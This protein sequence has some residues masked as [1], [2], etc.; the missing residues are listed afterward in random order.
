MGLIGKF[1]QSVAR[2]RAEEEERAQK[3]LARARTASEREKARAAI[4]QERMGTRAQIA[5]AKTALLKAEAEKKKAA[6]ALKEAG[7]GQDFFGGLRRMLVPTPAKK[8]R[9]ATRPK[10]TRK[11]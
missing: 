6:K 9:R 8:K 5:K 7:N 2:Y 4:Q 11:K 10:T 3:R 1:K